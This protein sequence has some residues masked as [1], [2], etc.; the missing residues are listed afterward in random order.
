[1]CSHIKHKN[2]INNKPNNL[3]TDFVQ[4]DSISTKGTFL[5]SIFVLIKDD[6]NITEK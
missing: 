4:T 5:S 6:N 3:E 2:K 1:M